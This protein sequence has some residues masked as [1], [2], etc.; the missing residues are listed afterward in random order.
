MEEKRD[1]TEVEFDFVIN[2]S[3]TFWLIGNFQAHD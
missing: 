1:W 3:E 2:R